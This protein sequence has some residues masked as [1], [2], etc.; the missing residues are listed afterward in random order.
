MARLNLYKNPCRKYAGGKRTC[1]CIATHLR[2]PEIAPA[3]CMKRTCDTDWVQP[4]KKMEVP[5]QNV[6]QRLF[7]KSLCPFS[8][9]S[10]S[11]LETHFFGRSK[12]DVLML[13]KDYCLHFTT[14]IGD[15]HPPTLGVGR[16]LQY[17]QLFTSRHRYLEQKRETPLLCYGWY[18]DTNIHYSHDET[19][20]RNL[21]FAS[22][23]LCK[24]TQR[25]SMQGLD[26][27]RA[28][29]KVALS[30]QNR[31]WLISFPPL[32]W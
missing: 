17:I 13:N 28:F 30:L 11:D 4:L 16:H 6:R 18:M 1:L 27:R 31:L 19:E 9:N 20:H 12:N 2:S 32:T 8:E 23:R 7:Q 5:N 26:I 24:F 25:F 15:R 3:I 21:T 14:R 29:T 10:L 22:V